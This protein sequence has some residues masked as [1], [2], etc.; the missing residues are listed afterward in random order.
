MA[1][2]E[3]EQ[4][5]Q[6]FDRIAPTYDAVNRVLSFGQ[7]II[8]RNRLC[9]AVPQEGSLVLLDIATGTADLLLAM[10]EKRQNIKAATGIDLSVNMLRLAQKKVDQKKL[11]T[12]IQ[13]IH[14]DG[15]ALP[16]SD[17]SFDI[18]SIA[19]GIRNIVERKRALLEIERV[20]KPQG[21]LLVLEFS[22]PQSALIRTLYLAYFRYILPLIGG[23]ISKEPGAYHYLNKTVEQF[24]PPWQFCESLGEAGFVEV[25]SNALSLGI[26]TLYSA[27][28]PCG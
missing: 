22:L 9:R 11:S 21:L 15:A 28:K 16:F 12:P 18:V 7:D 14:A 25:S 5:Y 6:M 10:C 24:S 19:F 27:R 2:S 17:H 8:W 20:L 1:A 23:L 3:Q 13:L 26:A 4:I